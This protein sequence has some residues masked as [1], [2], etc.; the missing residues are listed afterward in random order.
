MREVSGRLPR[1]NLKYQYVLFRVNCPWRLTP[2]GRRCWCKPCFWGFGGGASGI[3]R[4]KISRAAPPATV[5]RPRTAIP[6]SFAELLPSAYFFT[7][8][9]GYL[10]KYYLTACSSSG[11]GRCPHKAE[12]MGSNPIQA[13]TIYWW[14]AVPPSLGGRLLI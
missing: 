2:P 7:Y 14:E 8:K 12:I 6:R 9:A 10:V 11:L 3:M 4:V 13:A 5:K 1:R